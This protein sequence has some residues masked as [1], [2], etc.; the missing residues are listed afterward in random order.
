MKKTMEEFTAIIQLQKGE[1]EVVRG[2]LVA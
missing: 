2:Q 1:A